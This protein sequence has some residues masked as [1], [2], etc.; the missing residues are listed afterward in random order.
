[1]LGSILSDILL[2][3]RPR[4][5]SCWP[6]SDSLQVQGC[7]FIAAARW[8]GV[9]AVNAAVVDSVSSLMLIAAVALILPTVLY[10]TFPTT[11]SGGDGDDIK[12]KILVFSR[13]TAVVLLLIYVVY[14]YF[15]LWTHKDLFLDDNNGVDQDAYGEDGD[16]K[17]GKEKA[18]PAEQARPPLRD[19]YASV[20]LLAV[21][22]VVIFRCTQF[23]IENLDAMSRS[24]NI[25]KT[26]VAIV[27]IPLV[28][29]ACEFWQA[30]EAAG[31]K[32]LDFAI[33]VVIG[34]IL[35]IAL[36]VLPFLV[37]AGW[38]MDRPMDLYFETSQTFMLF[39]AVMVV[40]QVLQDVK[41]TYLHGVML[42]SM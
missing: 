18:G 33:N 8:T 38:F 37:V 5:R 41:Y 40:N 20:V 14:L 36:F 6:A 21:S 35:Q 16:K 30:V 19:V 39:L 32:K 24:L 10:S 2:V 4:S 3:C 25:N 31:Q 42:L 23:C 7:G 13:A 34:S 29:N 17:D 9:V 28:S 11:A 1:M 12:D 22:A 26:F 27:L 15:Q